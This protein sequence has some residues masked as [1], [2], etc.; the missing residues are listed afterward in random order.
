[1]STSCRLIH[2]VVEPDSVSA[3]MAAQRRWKAVNSAP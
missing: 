1:M 3:Q 2:S